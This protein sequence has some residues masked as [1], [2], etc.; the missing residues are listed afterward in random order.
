MIKWLKL[1]DKWMFICA[2]LV[3]CLIP[4]MFAVYDNHKASAEESASCAQSSQLPMPYFKAGTPSKPVVVQWKAIYAWQPTQINCNM[5]LSISITGKP[6]LQFEYVKLDNNN[7]Q[8]SFVEPDPPYRQIK[9]SS[10]EPVIIEVGFVEHQKE[11]A[12]LLITDPSSEFS[13][14]YVIIAGEL[15]VMPLVKK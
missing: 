14:T 9:C 1:N 15:V 2:A 8:C 3:V 5:F 6:D 12:I 10:K 13:Q 11:N 7:A 4:V